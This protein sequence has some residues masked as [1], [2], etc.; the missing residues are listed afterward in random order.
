[1]YVCTSIYL[2]IYLLSIPPC[3]C[4]YVCLWFVIPPPLQKG[5][6]VCVRGPLE[7]VFSWLVVAGG[8]G[9]G[10]ADGGDG[11]EDDG[12]LGRSGRCCRGK[13]E[14]KKNGSLFL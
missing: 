9:D 4:E 14:G 8:A 6:L 5:G 13:E 3:V 7:G 2:S 1:M 11:P 10:E 12:V